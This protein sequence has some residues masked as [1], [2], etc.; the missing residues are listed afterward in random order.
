MRRRVGNVAIELKDELVG[1]RRRAF[2]AQALATPGEYNAEA[3]H[4]W[5]EA[6]QAAEAAIT[7]YA[8]ETGQNRLEVSMAVTRAA[9][10]PAE[11][12]PTA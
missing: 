8:E 5:L 9:S 1:L 6:A 10:S 11:P 2:E 7:A 4:P 3:W 12:A